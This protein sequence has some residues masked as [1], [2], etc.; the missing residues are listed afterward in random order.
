VAK[1]RQAA[2]TRRERVEQMRREQ[3]RAERRRTAIIISAAV[4]LSL[5]I[6]GAAAFVPVKNWI[7]NPARKPMSAFGVPASEAG[8]SKIFNDSGAGINDHVDFGQS[9]DYKT[10]PPSSGPHWAQPASFE[11]K[12]YTPQDRPPLETLVHN[13]EHGYTIVWYDETIAKDS[14]QLQI[15]KDIARRFE[16]RAPT[17]L[18]EYNTKKFLVAPWKRDEGK[19]PAGKHLAFTHWSRT[20]GHRQYAEKVSG[21]AIERFM[22]RFPASDAP[23]PQGA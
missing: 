18:E 5:V 9:I 15:L 20:N 23:E 3:Q 2:A 12:F 17:N 8:L 10:T 22:K 16:G 13:L 19:F 6:I 7:T 11:R 14:E 4:L 1:R 21:E